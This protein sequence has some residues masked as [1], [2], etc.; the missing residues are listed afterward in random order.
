MNSSDVNFKSVIRIFQ[1]TMGRIVISRLVKKAC[2]A[3][4]QGGMSR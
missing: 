1:I 3:Y 2:P 4:Y